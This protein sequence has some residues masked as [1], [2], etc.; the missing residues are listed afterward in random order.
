M[1][2]QRK[3]PRTSMK[4]RIAISHPSAGELI[5][6]TR[7][8]SESGV[9]VRNA[10]LARL[11]IGTR[12]SG[13]VQGLPMEAPVLNMEVTRTDAEGAGLRFVDKG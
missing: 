5:G 10:D 4:C 7:D 2:N 1:A 8:L 11:P 13:Q 12:V 6:Q 3:Y 9:Y